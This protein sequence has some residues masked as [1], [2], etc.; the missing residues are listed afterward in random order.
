M[1]EHR[2]APL[3]DKRIKMLEI[4]LGCDMAYGP[5]ASYYTWLD[6]FTNVDLYYIEF[7]AAC[8]EQWANKTTEATIFAGDQ[9]SVPFLNQFIKKAGGDW[10]II[11]DDGGHT[12][13]QQR[14]SLS[15][16]WPYIKEGGIYFIEDLG[17]SYHPTY[18]GDYESD[19]TMMG[20]LKSM[21]DDNNRVAGISDKHPVSREVVSFEFTQEC[22]ALTK[23]IGPP[24][25][26]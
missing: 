10:D 23:F 16:L 8:A 14:T 24:V 20:D 3:R 15:V 26:V 9:A 5:G 25:E 17:T 4:G 13:E 21:L 18:G 22:V 19:D 11:I 12:M 2:L 7:D 1:Y 6:Y